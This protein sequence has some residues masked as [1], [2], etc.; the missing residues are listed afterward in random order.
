M[1]GGGPSSCRGRECGARLARRGH[2]LPHAPPP[3][4][5]LPLPLSE[6]LL[7]EAAQGGHHRS[8]WSVTQSQYSEYNFGDAIFF[9]VLRRL[10]FTLEDGLGVQ[11]I[12]IK[13]N[14]IMKFMAILLKKLNF[15]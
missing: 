7:Q 13:C 11:N 12:H 9:S 3:R 1:V 5:P 14:R 6:V 4:H 10:I 15:I 2:P 8:F